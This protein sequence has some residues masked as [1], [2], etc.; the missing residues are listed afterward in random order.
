MTRLTSPALEARPAE[1]LAFEDQPVGFE[2]ERAV[3]RR[4]PAHE[5]EFDA[6]IGLARL[7]AEGARMASRPSGVSISDVVQIR[8]TEGR[9]CSEPI[10]SASLTIELA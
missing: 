6:G 8:L 7:E 9:G 5:A 4:L 3:G 10:H 2:G 1:A